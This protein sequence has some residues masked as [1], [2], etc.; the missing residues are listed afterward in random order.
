MCYSFSKKTSTPSLKTGRRV[1][2]RTACVG[3][4]WLR[5]QVAGGWQSSTSTKKSRSVRLSN[6]LEMRSDNCFLLVN[7]RLNHHQPGVRRGLVFVFQLLGG[8]C[9]LAGNKPDLAWGKK[10]KSKHFLYVN[11][12]EKQDKKGLILK[13][14]KKRPSPAHDATT[15][16]SNLRLAKPQTCFDDSFALNFHIFAPVEHHLLFLV[17]TTI[18]SLS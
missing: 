15:A 7:T 12:E 17:T 2:Y 14:Q 4:V 18:I 11:T 16:H 3:S 13:E 5:K 9:G 8:R 6:I 1:L 10:E